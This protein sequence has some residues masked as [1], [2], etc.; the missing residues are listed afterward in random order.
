MEG[1]PI[2][3][4]NGSG[5]IKAGFAGECE[6]RV[7]HDNIFTALRAS[8]HV[9][10]GEDFA[11]ALHANT[12]RFPV[13][14]HGIVSQ[15]EGLLE[16]IQAAM[17][18]MKVEPE[19]HPILLTE[20]PLNPMVHRELLVERLFEEFR[21]PSLQVVD[22]GSLALYGTNSRTGLVIEVGD[23]VAQTVPLYDSYVIFNAVKRRDYGGRDLTAYLGEILRDKINHR[24]IH[25]KE[26]ETWR[27]WRDVKEM[28]CRVRTNSSV[29]EDTQQQT[30]KL[31][32]GKFVHRDDPYL[33]ECAEALFEP[34]R[35]LKRDYEEEGIHK[36]AAQSILESSRDIQKELAGNIV[37]SGGSMSFPGMCRR[38]E[39]ELQK[40]LPSTMKAAVKMVKNPTYAAFTGGSIVAS[41]PALLETFM[42]RSEYD[43]NGAAFIHK[44][45]VRLTSP[46]TL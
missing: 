45:S 34:S 2:V 24:P 12:Y 18:E 38:V 30:L 15:W 7:V 10:G 5:S 21:V 19:R 22:S 16:V 46:P 3:L 14:D 32:D 4:D 20:A 44:K 1:T 29:A 25:S 11:K 39:E 42:S 40:L 35:L 9:P 41:M 28:M 37:L 27:A 31:P 43:E 23:G 33:S 17:D 6:P 26:C 36:M 8:R 13:M